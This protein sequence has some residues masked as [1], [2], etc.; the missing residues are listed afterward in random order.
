[1]TTGFSIFSYLQE[2]T[3][4]IPIRRFKGVLILILMS[5]KL[6]LANQI[7][8]GLSIAGTCLL[9]TLSG[10]SEEEFTDQRSSHFKLCI[11]VNFK[12]R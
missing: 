8:T 4:L 1:M 10:Q 5:G 6:F 12:S 11:A 3:F 2:L 9:K 7:I